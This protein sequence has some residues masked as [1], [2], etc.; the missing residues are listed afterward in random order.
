MLKSN[1]IINSNNIFNDGIKVLNEKLDKIQSSTELKINSKFSS[2]ED[3]LN[4]EINSLRNLIAENSNSL[5]ENL[6]NQE[7]I[8]N[9]N[10]KENTVKVSNLKEN[11]INTLN[12]QIK[13]NTKKNTEFYQFLLAQDKK[14]DKLNVSFAEKSE[15]VCIYFTNKDGNTKKLFLPKPQN[16]YVPDEK[17]ITY[18]NGKISLVNS[19]SSNDF[20]IQGTEINVTGMLLNNGEHL[21]ADQINNDLKNASRNISFLTS[22]LENTIK[23][24]NNINGYIASNNFKK[25]V[26][27][28]NTLNEFAINCI[29]KAADKEITKNLIPNGTKIKNTYDNHIWVFNRISIDGLTTDK[30]EDFGA[31][32]ICIANNDGVLGLVTGSQDKYRGYIDLKGTISINGLEEDISKIIDSLNKLIENLNTYQ[33]NTNERLTKIENLLCIKEV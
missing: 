9:N 25:S 13:E 19:Y 14:I 10:L 3:K 21:S 5:K 22:K 4:L 7:E 23:K 32:N 24:L 31:D 29:S 17:T 15:G 11:I 20:K 1:T 12:Q 28:Q 26:P 30:W 6:K 27:E 8:L 33:V 16:K 18:K 2:I